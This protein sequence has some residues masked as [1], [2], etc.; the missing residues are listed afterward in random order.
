MLRRYR[1]SAPSRTASSSVFR[2][3]QLHLLP[4]IDGARAV[5]ILLHGAVDRGSPVGNLRVYFKRS[6]LRK[7]MDRP[8]QSTKY[9]A[10]VVIQAS[11]MARVDDTSSN[12]L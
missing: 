6:S 8:K 2:P 1:V 3:D 12:V 5:A 11:N 10:A 9:M 4:F 7:S